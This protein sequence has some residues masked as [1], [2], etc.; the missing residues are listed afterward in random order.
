MKTFFMLTLTFVAQA[1]ATFLIYLA[2]VKCHLIIFEHDFLMLPPLIALPAYSF[3]I[4]DSLSSLK[5]PLRAALCLIAA[6]SCAFASLSSAVFVAF[7]TYG[8]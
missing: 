5:L 2:R 4:W 7:N 1:I 3:L 6:L 8:T